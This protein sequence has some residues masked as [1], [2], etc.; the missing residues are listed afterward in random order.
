MGKCKKK[1][2]TNYETKATCSFVFPFF[3]F[4]SFFSSLLFALSP[5]CQ[6]C[7]RE[8]NCVLFIVCL[9]WKMHAPARER[10]HSQLYLIKLWRLKFILEISNPNVRFGKN[11]LMLVN[12]HFSRWLHTN[13]PESFLSRSLIK[14]YCVTDDVLWVVFFLHTSILQWNVFELVAPKELC[15]DFLKP[16]A[17]F[18]HTRNEHQNYAPISTMHFHKNS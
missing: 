1:F 18:I 2:E 10:A 12:W 15:T 5:L 7:W 3:P 9:C 16:I 8:I 6:C 4:F 13:A 11:R 17:R 14:R